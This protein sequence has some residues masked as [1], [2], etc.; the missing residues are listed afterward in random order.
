MNVFNKIF[1]KKISKNIG[2]ILKEFP[3]PI[4]QITE[5][6]D[7]I[8]STYRD[9]NSDKLIQEKELAEIEAKV[10]TYSEYTNFHKDTLNKGYELEKKE[11]ELINLI[12]SKIEVLFDT[13]KNLHEDSPKFQ[14]Y[15]E[16]I[17]R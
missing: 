2:V 10:N 7:S 14:M 1:D 12:T 9:I 4:I 17:N 11:L 6:L 16:Q 3:F 15:I 13:V 5:T 8:I